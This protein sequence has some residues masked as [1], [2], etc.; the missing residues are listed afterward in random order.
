[1]NNKNGL[2]TRTAKTTGELFVR[3]IGQGEQQSRKICGYA[4]LF[5]VPSVTLFKDGNYE[6]R[7]VI[8]KCAISQEFLNSCDIKMTMY[9]NRQIV[10]A[11]SDKGKGTLYYRVDPKGVYF[12]FDAPKT[13]HGDEALE[14]V[15]RGD[16][17]GCSFVFSTYYN[18]DNFVKR[19]TEKINGIECVTCHVRKMTGIYDFTITTDPAYPD[20]SVDARERGKRE[21]K[22]KAWR[23][24]ELIRK[25]REKVYGQIQSHKKIKKSKQ[26]IL[27]D[28]RNKINNKI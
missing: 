23:K 25:I 8:D 13:Q 18:D 12:E 11:R 15:R 3:T 16:I 4:I 10:L 27:N 22:N 21:A 28:L 9:H 19:V 6:E 1:M 2:V 5:G 26:E 17:N 20:T 7:E 14:L 24:A